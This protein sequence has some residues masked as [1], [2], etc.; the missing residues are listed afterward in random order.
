MVAAALVVLVALSPAASP[1]CVGDGCIN[2]YSTEPGGGALATSWD[3]TTRVVPTFEVFCDAG[4]CLF[5]AIDP[6][7]LAG[8]APEPSGYH[9]L[10]EGVRVSFEVI[11]QDAGASIRLG[12]GPIQPGSSAV[13]GTTP[14]LHNHPSWQLLLPEGDAG[15]YEIEFRL[16]TDSPDYEDSASYTARLTNLPPPTATPAATA[17]AEPPPSCPGDCNGDGRVSIAE[18]V[19]GVGGA[20]GGEGCTAFDRNGDGT[21]G[22]NELVTAVNA[23]L[24]GC[25][26]G[27]TPTAT[28]PPTLEA[29]QNT[30]FSPRCATAT[31]HDSSFRSG[32]LLL[33]EG[34]AYGELVGIEPEI[35]TARD[36]GL[37]RVDPGDPENSFLLIK[38]EGPP[39]SQGSRMP[40]TGPLLTPEEVDL[41]RAWISA[42]APP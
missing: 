16:T 38:L 22:I 25:P 14:E 28:R 17:T 26:A 8:F 4:Q 31:C 6:G 33:E 36:A 35:E 40:L 2:I 9:R 39:P 13:I 11:A 30:I 29:I 23:A 32:D 10:D 21:I 5:S 18:L 27:A 42:G 12:G 15:E 24:D 34:A 7:F 37:L 41:I 19:R 1:A 3:F 20:L